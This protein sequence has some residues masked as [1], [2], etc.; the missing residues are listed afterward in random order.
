MKKSLLAAGAFL[1]TLPAGVAIAEDDDYGGERGNDGY[2]RGYDDDSGYNGYDRN[3]YGYGYRG[4][5]YNAYYRNYMRF[6][7]ECR[8]HRRLHREL[9]GV[10]GDAHDEG[11]EYRGEHGDAHGALD[12]THDQYHRNRPVANYCPTYQE[13]RGN[14]YRSRNSYY[15]W[16]SGYGGGY[17]RNY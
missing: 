12:A 1:L 8:K 9:K 2:S 13:Y 5:Q 14:Y 4:G 10:H 3:D 11:F 16:N 15:N 6:L 7:R 17:R